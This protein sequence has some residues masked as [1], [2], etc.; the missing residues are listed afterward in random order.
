MTTAAVALAKSVGYQNAGTVEFLVDS[1][2]PLTDD[3]P[4]YFIEANARLQ[5]EHTITEEVM[6]LDLVRAQLD[7]RG[8]RSRWNRSAFPRAVH[9]AASPFRRA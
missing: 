8:R 4:F 1:S 7:S 5:V 2:Q 3:S 9:R 6:G